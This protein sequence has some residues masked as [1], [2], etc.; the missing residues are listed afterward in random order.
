MIHRSYF[1][2]YQQYTTDTAKTAAPTNPARPFQNQ[3]CNR[4]NRRHPNQN[5]PARSM[6]P[7]APSM[8]VLSTLAER[9]DRIKPPTSSPQP[10]NAESAPIRPGF[11]RF[12]PPFTRR[13]TATKSKGTQIG[14][15]QCP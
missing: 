3:C 8:S 15:N 2:R 12:N 6:I 4:P 13:F 11:S 1:V 5:I 10:E 14:K 7:K 9:A